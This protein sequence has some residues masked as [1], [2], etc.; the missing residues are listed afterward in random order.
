MQ[1]QCICG[2][3]KLEN[4]YWFELSVFCSCYPQI[5]AGGHLLAPRALTAHFLWDPLCKADVMSAP[6]SVLSSQET[7]VEGQMVPFPT[8]L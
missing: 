1:I 2:E 5:P 7:E 8:P 6:F 4:F 3:W